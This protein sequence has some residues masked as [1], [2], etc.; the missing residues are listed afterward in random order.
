MFVINFK[1]NYF[2]IIDIQMNIS[3]YTYVYYL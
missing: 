2:L 3:L 1:L